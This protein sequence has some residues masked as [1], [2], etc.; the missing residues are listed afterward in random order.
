[1]SGV[2]WIWLAVAALLVFVEL[3]HVAFYAMFVA[4]G[5]VGAALVAAYSPESVLT[6]GIVFV[7]VATAG[8]VAV[9]PFVSH[10]FERGRKGGHPIKG[11]HGG[12]VGQTAITLDEVGDAHHVGHVQLAGERWLAVRGGGPMIPAS[13]PVTVTAVQGTTLVVTPSEGHAPHAGDAGHP[14][15]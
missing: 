9:R 14:H 12:L 15:A 8:V 1:V 13:T 10:A 3:H 5:A 4:L 6:Q 2:F 11:V 7:V